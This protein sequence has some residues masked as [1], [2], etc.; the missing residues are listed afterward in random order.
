LYALLTGHPPFSG[1]PAEVIRR[2]LIES[3]QPP[4]QLHLAIPTAFE[5]I[6]LR[7]LAKRPEDRFP[8]AAAVMSELQRMGR[9]EGLV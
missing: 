8:D 6:V 2:I 4:K 5:G 9:Y 7:M 1:S 3:P